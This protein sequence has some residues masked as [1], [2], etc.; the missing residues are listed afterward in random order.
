MHLESKWNSAQRDR[1]AARMLD[2]YR[3]NEEYFEYVHDDSSSE[4]PSQEE[5]EMYRV[6]AVNHKK[7]PDEVSRVLE[8]GCGRAQSIGALLESIGKC[9]YTGIEAS[10]AAVGAS[11][12]VVRV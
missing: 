3:S 5:R 2:Y 1:L 11:R 8:L 6:I 10:V 4:R 12:R 7:V 9:K